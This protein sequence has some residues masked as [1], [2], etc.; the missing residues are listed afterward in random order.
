M[1]RLEHQGG[2]PPKPT[3]LG[4]NY[5]GQGS[6]RTSYDEPRSAGENY[7]PSAYQSTKRRASSYFNERLSARTSAV[8]SSPRKGKTRD[9]GARALVSRVEHPVHEGQGATSSLEVLSGLRGNIEGPLS[10]SCAEQRVSG[11]GPRK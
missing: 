9:N 3:D 1:E 2:T 5:C 10:S 8:Q 4:P 11:G 7:S 6:P